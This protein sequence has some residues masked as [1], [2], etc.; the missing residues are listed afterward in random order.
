MESYY[1]RVDLYFSSVSATLSIPI[2][3]SFM[4]ILFFCFCFFFFRCGS[5]FHQIVFFDQ[6]TILACYSLSGFLIDDFFAP[7]I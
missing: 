4:I 5:P 1:S 7:L 6:G 3:Y 2:G